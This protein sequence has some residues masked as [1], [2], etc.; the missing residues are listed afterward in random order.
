MRIQKETEKASRSWT[1]KIARISRL[2]IV[3]LGAL[4][5]ATASVEGASTEAPPE[6][7]VLLAQAAGTSAA[8]PGTAEPEPHQM[9]ASELNQQI[10]NPVGNVW[11]LQSQ[12]QNFKLSN[13]QWNNVW[14][15]QPGLPV[16][17]TKDWNLITR[18][19]IPF[20][21]IVPHE[22]APGEFTRTAGF[23]DITLSEIF[24]PAHAGNWLLGAGPTF[25][26]PSASSTFTGQGKVAVGPVGLV[27]YMTKDFILGVFPQ[28]WFAIAGSP[29]RPYTSNLNLQPIATM[30]F[31]DGWD[32]GYSGNIL[33]NWRAPSGDVWTV[34]VGLN[35]GKVVKF[36][37]L[38]VKLQ[39]A[40][41][42]MPVHPNSGPKYNLQIQITPVIPKLIKGTLFE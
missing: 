42:Y 11:S 37:P 36:G 17:L 15:F 14:N 9:S 24:S 33:A 3:M 28:Q 7:G 2:S 10:T 6:N 40:A 23:G 12:F 25:I 32:V 13:G 31:G 29:S 8:A 30:F 41:Q 26:F 39:L 19:V 18:P 22:T 16:S 34:P 35:I 27:G 4:L 5:S 20:Y 21:N 1:V 38:P